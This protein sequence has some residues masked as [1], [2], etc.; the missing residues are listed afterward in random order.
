[1]SL[2]KWNWRLG[3]FCFSF[4]IASMRHCCPFFYFCWAFNQKFHLN[5]CN[6][7][8]FRVV[9]WLNCP[10]RCDKFVFVEFLLVKFHFLFDLLKSYFQANI[11][12]SLF[13]SS[14][15]S[16]LYSTPPHTEIFFYS[17]NEN[18]A[19]THKFIELYI[20]IYFLSFEFLSIEL[21]LLH[22]SFDWNQYTFRCTLFFFLHIQ[23]VLYF[24]FSMRFK[25][26]ENFKTVSCFT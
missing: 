23:V 11:F 25:S 17:R 2:P 22:T 3:S 8:F 21:C 16:T 12:E 10:F 18:F 9:V 4:S 26:I 7:N 6:A 14:I 24:S 20:Y 19:C 1:M 5:L 13:F 15:V